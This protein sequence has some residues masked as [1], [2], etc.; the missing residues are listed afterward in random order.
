[1][2]ITRNF[3]NLDLTVVPTPDLVVYII[4]NFFVTIIEIFLF[5]IVTEL[6]AILIYFEF[7]QIYVHFV[8][9]EVIV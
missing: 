7:G 8:M 4:Y 1:M 3:I 6:M 9:A 5:G 2:E